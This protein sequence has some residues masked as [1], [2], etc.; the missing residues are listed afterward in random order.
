LIAIP[1][2]FRMPVSNTD[3]TRMFCLKLLG[4]TSA[5]LDPKQ[6]LLPD[7][8][9]VSCKLRQADDGRSIDVTAKFSPQFVSRLQVDGKAELRFSLPRALPARVICLPEKP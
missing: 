8:S 9:G 6:I 5:R 7:E 1:G 4:D 3:V 2:T